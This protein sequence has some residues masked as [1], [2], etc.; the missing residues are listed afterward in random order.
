M[1]SSVFFYQQKIFLFDETDGGAH[2]NVVPLVELEGQVP[3]GLDPLG[4]GGV[5]HRLA[6][7]ADG[8][9]FS[10][11]AVPGPRHPRHLCTVHL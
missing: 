7:G 10:Q 6:G 8:D 1:R 9:G 4:V 5:H 11:L 3:V 2:H